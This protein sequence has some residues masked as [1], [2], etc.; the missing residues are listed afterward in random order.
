V[1]QEIAVEGMSCGHCEE[2]VEKSLRSVGSVTSATADHEAGTV[3]VEGD[4]TRESLVAAI[5]EAG[6]ETAE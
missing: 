5:H 1:S 4:A 3:T 6:Y 2:T